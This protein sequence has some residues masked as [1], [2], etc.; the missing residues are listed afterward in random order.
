ME[1]IIKYY[2]DQK[3]VRVVYTVDE[4]GV[5]QGDYVSYYKNGQL[6]IKCAN[7]DGKNE[8]TFKKYWENGNLM[9]ECS[10]K[11]GKFNGPYAE[12]DEDGFLNKKGNYVDNE[13]TDTLGVA[14]ARSNLN[15]R[16]RRIAQKDISSSERRSAI[17]GEVFKFRSYYPKKSGG[18][19]VK[20]VSDK[21][22]VR[23]PDQNVKD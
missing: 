18:C 2:P 1:T 7:K 12:Y 11:D 14:A 3:T 20:K 4:Q 6:K 19:A 21:A 17:R 15:A 22:V 16:L 9:I 10:F 5:M 8:G 13:Y 23:E